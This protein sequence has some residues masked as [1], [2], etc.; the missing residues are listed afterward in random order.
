[1]SHLLCPVFEDQLY[2]CKLL[3]YE[4]STALTVPLK[5]LLVIV[6]FWRHFNGIN[7]VVNNLL[8]LV[9]VSMELTLLCENSCDW[10]TNA[11]LIMIGPKRLCGLS[12]PITS[13][14]QPLSCGW[15]HEKRGKIVTDLM[16]IYTICTKNKFSSSRSCFVDL[17]H[18][19][20]PYKKTKNRLSYDCN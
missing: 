19:G 2:L 14:F 4:I 3:K 9:A 6:K 18:E 5:S 12:H 16:I 20:N 11:E 8:L 10:P 17:I 15:N 7:V 1:M 13:D